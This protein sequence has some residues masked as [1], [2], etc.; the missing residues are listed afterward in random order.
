MDVVVG[1][2]KE[3]KEDL[4]ELNKKVNFLYKNLGIQ[5]ENH[6]EMPEDSEAIEAKQK[7]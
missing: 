6:G 4:K 1:A 7:V 2:K 3:I 5:A